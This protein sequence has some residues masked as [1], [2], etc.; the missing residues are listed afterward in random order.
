MNR[1]PTR[2]RRF[3]WIDVVVAVLGLLLLLLLTMELWL[4]HYGVH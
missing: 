3:E 1:R 4:P 2:R